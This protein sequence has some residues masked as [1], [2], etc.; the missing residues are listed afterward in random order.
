MFANGIKQEKTI[1]LVS[2]GKEEANFVDNIIVYLKKPK[3]SME[4]YDKP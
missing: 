3:E 2:I 1:K 4:K